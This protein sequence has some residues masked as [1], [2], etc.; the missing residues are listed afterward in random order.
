MDRRALPSPLLLAVIRGCSVACDR[1]S[2][3]F[4]ITADLPC[5][6][7]KDP[8]DALFGALADPFSMSW[9]GCS[10]LVRPTLINEDMLRAVRWAISSSLDLSRPTLAVFFLPKWPSS[11]Y[12]SLLSHQHVH[13]L[14]DLPKG[15]ACL[16][17]PR[18]L[19]P[20][21]PH[22]PT[23]VVARQ[24]VVPDAFAVTLFLVANPAGLAQFYRPLEME[25]ALVRAAISLKK[26]LWLLR[27]VSAL[28]SPTSTML[29]FYPP[30]NFPTAELPSLR[31]ALPCVLPGSVAPSLLFSHVSTDSLCYDWSAGLYTD[32]ACVTVDSANSLG[33]A[34]YDG[35]RNVTCTIQPSGHG[36]TNTIARA[37]LAGI[38]MATR[39]PP[40]AS[41]SCVTMFTD[42]L[43][44]MYLIRRFLYY[45]LTLRES[46]HFHMLKEICFTLTARAREGI[47]TLLRKVKAHSRCVGNEL[48]EIGAT[49]AAR[50]CCLH[51]CVLTTPNNSVSFLPAWPV[52]PPSPAG[53]GGVPA[54]LFT[55]SNLRSSLTEHL[56]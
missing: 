2:S 3:P 32:G 42:S 23:S 43:T 1:L 27:P 33:A 4:E 56:P 7:S 25:S 45:P 26:P 16:Y 18:R 44:S 52:V 55:V 48:A 30:Q 38:L 24:Q 15:S 6:C 21:V 39:V 17:S 50:P 28:P 5:Y 9:A 19:F 36:A 13:S 8:A 53:G 14:A 22:A 47:T 20:P 51:D 54:E 41:A 34:F 10:S 49:S 11:A 37:E 29:P 40:P 12:R 31:V 35:R 46:K